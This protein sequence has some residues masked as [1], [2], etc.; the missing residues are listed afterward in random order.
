[1][2]RAVI[3]WA[4]VVLLAMLF[5]TLTGTAVLAAE[6]GL[7]DSQGALVVAVIPE[8]PASEAGLARGDVILAVGEQT[9][10]SSA[11]LRGMV[12]EV[13]PGDVVTLTVLHGD[14]EYTVDVEL[15]DAGGHA[16]LGVYLARDIEASA[17]EEASPEEPDVEEPDTD[18]TDADDV[19][20]DDV[21]TD[22]V[23]ADD[24]DAD[25]ADADDADADDADADETHADAGEPDTEDAGEDEGDDHH[26]G[27][28]AVEAE[29]SSAEESTVP[30]VPD[31]HGM[32]PLKDIAAG[33]LVF[34]VLEESPADD[35]GISIGDVI[36][37]IDGARFTHIDD[38]AD[39]VDAH[40]PGDAILLELLRRNGS[41]EEVTVTLGEHPKED[42]Q[43]FLGI[44]YLPTP[45]RMFL[46]HS[47][48]GDLLVPPIP[49][50]HDD[51]DNGRPHRWWPRMHPHHQWMP[52]GHP[53]SHDC[54]GGMP[55]CDDGDDD[56]DDDADTYEEGDEDPGTK[57]DDN[58][59]LP[60]VI[61]A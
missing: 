34:G 48:D 46:G 5:I 39:T 41:L 37:G 12:Q 24:A 52:D 51:Y 17:I 16:F 53:K 31:E 25:D 21:D 58:T 6:P 40:H 2:N 14:E 60:T 42:G 9:V 29:G 45:R 13:A 61:A 23:D 38:L 4:G 44:R 36:L 32:T 20:A 19:D 27:E 56:H 1:M 3:R 50:D 47:E 26:A 18:M 10:G 11:D 15:A 59:R 33:A 28:E 43:A 49:F 55:W 35:A 7:D 8:S 22:D 54:D 57:G 30:S